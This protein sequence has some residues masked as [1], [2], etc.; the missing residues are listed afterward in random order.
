MSLIESLNLF[1]WGVKSLYIYIYVRSE[2]SVGFAKTQH[3]LVSLIAGRGSSKALSL[4]AENDQLAGMTRAEKK[5]LHL[6]P[7]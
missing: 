3:A 2:Q 5:S 6:L 7:G 4:P 1:H